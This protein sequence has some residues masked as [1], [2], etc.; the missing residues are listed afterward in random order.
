[1]FMHTTKELNTREELF[2][3]VW[4]SP[5]QRVMAEPPNCMILDAIPTTVRRG[6][7]PDRTIPN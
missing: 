1:M 2:E 5:I 3:M 7:D 4:T 6:F